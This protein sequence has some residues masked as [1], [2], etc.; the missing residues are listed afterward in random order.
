MTQFYAVRIDGKTRVL[1]SQCV[2]PISQAR[3]ESIQRLIDA[4][5]PE[6]C[7]VEEILDEMCGE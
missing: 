3:A 6:E 1:S 7:I 4:G 5:M 2:M